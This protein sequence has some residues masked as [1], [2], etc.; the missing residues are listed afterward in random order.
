MDIRITIKMFDFNVFAFFTFISKLLRLLVDPILA[1]I[2]IR[3]KG[4]VVKS[5]NEILT[6]TI[7]ELT[8]KIKTQEVNLRH[9]V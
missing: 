4:S 2:Y 5:D 6:L 1:L 9:I 7:N 8:T 3:E